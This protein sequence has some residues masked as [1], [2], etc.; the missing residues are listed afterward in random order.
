M[1]QRL[2]TDPLDINFRR[3][4]ATFGSDIQGKSKNALVT[5]TIIVGNANSGA[6]KP[7]LR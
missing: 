6:S 2:R 4:T 3:R 5:I 7:L 1:F